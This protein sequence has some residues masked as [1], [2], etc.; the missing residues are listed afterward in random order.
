[1]HNASKLQ[2]NRPT[3][4]GRLFFFVGGEMGILIFG[5][6]EAFEIMSKNCHFFLNILAKTALE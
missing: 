4:V 5:R 6:Q 2:K 1:V 3:F